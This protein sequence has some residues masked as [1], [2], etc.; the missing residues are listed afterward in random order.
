MSRLEK[1][2]AMLASEP[3]DPF[4]R[5]AIAMEMQ[6][7]DRMPE[8]EAAFRE[9]IAEQPPYVPAYLM[10]AQW[11]VRDDRISEARTVLREGI[12]QARGQGDLHAASEMGELLASVGMLGGDDD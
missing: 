6:G 9:L 5:Y 7:L 4:L 2:Q 12:G 3:R 11:L 10:L 1:L 8:A